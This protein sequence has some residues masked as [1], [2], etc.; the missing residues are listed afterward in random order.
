MLWILAWY[1]VGSNVLRGG[2]DRGWLIPWALLLLTL[3]PLRVLITRLQGW[4]A[5][6]AGALLKQRLFF[7][8]LRL[9][10][11]SLR[12][13]GAGQLLGRVLESEA[14]EALALSGGFLAFV[15]LIE[16]IASIFVLAAGAGGL[17]HSALA[18]ALASGRRGAGLDVLPAAIA[19]G[20]TFAW[21]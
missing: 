1:V 21:P 16:I 3:V 14:V 20:P 11:D 7:G 12:H 18:L 9:E 8:S 6:G 10:P 19:I 13:Q 4:V 5:I 17:L 2:T 15:A